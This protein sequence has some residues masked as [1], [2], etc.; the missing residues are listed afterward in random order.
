MAAAER[1]QDRPVGVR[2]STEEGP[3]LR[4]ATAAAARADADETEAVATRDRLRDAPLPA[5]E[6]DEEI[7]GLLAQGEIVHGLRRSAILRAPGDDR[8]LGYGGTLYVTSHRLIHLGQ[9]TVNVPLSNIL[10]TE[11]AGERLLI[12][13]REGEGISLDVDRPRVL[14]VEIGAAL[15]EA[16]R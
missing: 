10:E 8:A 3:A 11:L 9:V 15:R 4:D 6:A 13:L 16:R 12:T 7:A 5:L 14:R 1:D 2:G